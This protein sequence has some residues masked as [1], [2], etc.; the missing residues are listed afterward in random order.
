MFVYMCVVSGQLR[1]NQR[2]F[3]KGDSLLL[4][5]VF[6]LLFSLYRFSLVW[7]GQGWWSLVKFCASLVKSAWSNLETFVQVWSSLIKVI[8]VWSSLIMFG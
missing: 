3:L 4:Y 7:F 5:S 8:Q 2:E 6:V 1:L